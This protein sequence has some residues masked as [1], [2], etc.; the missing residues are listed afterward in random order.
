MAPIERTAYPRFKRFMSAREL[1][2]AVLAGLLANTA[3]GLW[4]ADPVIALGIAALAV[5]QGR[6]AWEGEEDDDD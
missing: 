4:R 5:H 3:F 6:E 2:I 1:A